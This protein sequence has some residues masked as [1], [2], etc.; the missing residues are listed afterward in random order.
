MTNE[1]YLEIRLRHLLTSKTIRE[2]D[3]VDRNTKKYI[4]DINELD[5]RMELLVKYKKAFEILTR[6]TFTLICTEDEYL[7]NKTYYLL[8]DLYNEIKKE[9]YELL[10]ELMK[11]EEDK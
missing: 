10:A 7:C 11:C 3:N 5:E 8:A 6:D 2:Y 1:E 9:E 4:K